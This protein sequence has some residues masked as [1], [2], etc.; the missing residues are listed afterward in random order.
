LPY[1]QA[2]FIARFLGIMGF[3][4]GLYYLAEAYPRYPGVAA[5]QYPNK[6]KT[7]YTFETVD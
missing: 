5:K 1:T 4:I 6:G 3:F 7:H 2:E